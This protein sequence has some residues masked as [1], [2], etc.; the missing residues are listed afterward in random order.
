[1][2]V[3]LIV[4]AAGATCCLAILLHNAWPILQRYG[5]RHYGPVEYVGGPA[6]VMLW[7][8][9]LLALC[10]GHA[11]LFVIQHYYNPR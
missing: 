7:P 11:A 2:D 9:A 6:I 1:M 4:Y 5:L 10:L 8:L 3:G